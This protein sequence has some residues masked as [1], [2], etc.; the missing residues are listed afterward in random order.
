MEAGPNRGSKEGLCAECFKKAAN[1]CAK[2]KQR[3]YCSSYCQQKDW[4]LGH[5]GECGLQDL[6]QSKVPAPPTRLIREKVEQPVLTE[7]QWRGILEAVK[8]GPHPEPPRGLRNLGNSCYMNAVLQGIFH[9][10]PALFANCREHRNR[11]RCPVSGAG[12]LKP[13]QGCFRCDLEH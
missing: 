10:A 11:A 9:G 6:P 13:G 7:K 5:R 8:L 12:E 2:C 3:W 1:H 4:L